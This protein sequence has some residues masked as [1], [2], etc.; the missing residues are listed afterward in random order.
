MLRRKKLSTTIG[1]N[2][3]EYLYKMVKADKA[4]GAGE[5]V[6]KAVEVAR[7]LDSR[8]ALERA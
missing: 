5:A 8:A 3:F 1:A 4:A 2:N 7:R 6:H